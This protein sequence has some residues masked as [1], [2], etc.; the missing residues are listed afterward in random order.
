MAISPQKI[1]ELAAQLLPKVTEQRRHLHAHP[2]L[3]FQEFHTSDYIAKQL[4]ELGI[5]YTKGYVKTGIVALIEGKNPHNKVFAIRGDMDALPITEKTGLPFSSTNPGVMHACGH[6]VHTSCVLGAAALLNSLKSEFEGTIQ[7][8]FQ[9]GEEVL[10]GGA[11]LMIAEGALNS[12]VPDAI[13]GQHV[14]PQ[15]D[16]G[17]VGFRPGMYMASTDEIHIDVIG[18][19]GH[20]AEP[21]RIVNP[22][23]IASKII[24]ELYKINELGREKGIPTIVSVGYIQGLGATNVV[25]DMV[26]LKGTFRTLN[27]EWR[28]EVLEM[29]EKISTQIAS[30]MGGKVDVDL[31]KGYPYLE[32]DVDLTLRA[33]QYA[34]ELLGPENVLDLDLRMGGEDFSYY[35]QIMPGCFFRLGTSTPGNPS[36]GL[37][38]PTFT[39]DESALK[40]GMSVLSWIALQ[41]LNRT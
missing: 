10:P 2:E 16:A 11:S 25:P 1:H 15:M 23:V 18:K 12:P 13:I 33:K 21:D 38:T 17:K 5:P 32:N 28:T 36:S 39:V 22:L 20:A 14:F 41:E 30:E 34:I 37:H 8:I 4:D 9:P 6:D 24:L 19:G 29:M 31:R 40:V 7:L 3:S 27:E 26:A 35:T